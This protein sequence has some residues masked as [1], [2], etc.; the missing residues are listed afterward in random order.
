[1]EG[2]NTRTQLFKA[3]ADTLLSD[4]FDM[5]PSFSDA[6]MFACNLESF[7]FGRLMIR[8]VF[9]CFIARHML[10]ATCVFVWRLN[11]CSML[12]L[13]N[14]STAMSHLGVIS[15][16]YHLDV[17]V[18]VLFLSKAKDIGVVANLSEHKIDFDFC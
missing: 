8:Q 14:M 13:S 2:R 17:L 7:Y 4:R 5:G 3:T 6:V 16:E 10:A 12:H 1:M 9:H 18:L 15:K 11:K